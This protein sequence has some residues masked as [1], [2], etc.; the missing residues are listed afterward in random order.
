MVDS[1][2]VSARQIKGGNLIELRGE[3]DALTSEGLVEQLSAGPDSLLVIDLDRLSFMDSSGLGAIHSARRNAARVGTTLV[4]ARPQPIVQRVLEITGLD[5]WL[6]DRDPQW[7]A[8]SGESEGASS[9]GSSD[10]VRGVPSNA[11]KNEQG[12][13]SN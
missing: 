7:L 4:L 8:D 10:V 1:F 2:G 12:L 6:T 13:E 3:L 11:V 9:I 5:V